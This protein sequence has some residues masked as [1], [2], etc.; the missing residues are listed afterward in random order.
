MFLPLSI[1]NSFSIDNT[2]KRYNQPNRDSRFMQHSS[3]NG[4]SQF[5][6]QNSYAHRNGAPFNGDNNR[7]CPPTQVDESARA[8]HS[9]WNATQESF[10][11]KRNY[12]QSSLSNSST[13]TQPAKIS[14][15][16]WS[17]APGTDYQKSATNGSARPHAYVVPPIGSAYVNDSDVSSKPAVPSAYTSRPPV[18]VQR[19][20]YP[21]LPRQAA[22]PPSPP[23]LPTQAQ[24]P[25]QPYTHAVPSATAPTAPYSAAA[26]PPNNAA[27][28]QSYYMPQ[29]APPSF[30]PQMYPAQG[31]WAPPGY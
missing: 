10:A 8:S 9:S 24:W 5:N 2:T 25:V 18:T 31:Q 28:Q 26:P 29:P 27:Y 21:T 13:Y 20:V 23:P 15:S 30:H 19:S 14:R 16:G 6:N 4:A 3:Q 1:L 17:D 11:E 7:S 12:S 22:A